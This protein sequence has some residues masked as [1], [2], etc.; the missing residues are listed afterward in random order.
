MKQPVVVNMQTITPMGDYIPKT[1]VEDR[2][3]AADR[4]GDAGLAKEEKAA[5][6]IWECRPGIF[7]RAVKQREFS[8]FIAGHC[9]FTPDG[10]E[11]IEIRAGD[12]VYFPADCN[13]TWDVREPLR[14]TYL[15]VE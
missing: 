12:A 7:R 5:A 11:A 4:I 2:P 6:G 14:K 10:G 13:G 9:F 8:H 3:V 1:Q 15:I